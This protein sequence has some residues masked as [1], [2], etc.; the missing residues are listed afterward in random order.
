M[1]RDTEEQKA[2]MLDQLATYLSVTVSDPSNHGPLLLIRREA[3][4]TAQ[5][6]K[7]TVN[8]FENK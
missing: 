7:E 8:D 3:S 2:T 1:R 4:L 6:V 5:A